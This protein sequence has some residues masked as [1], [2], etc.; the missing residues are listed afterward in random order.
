[1]RIFLGIYVL[2]IS[3]LSSINVFADALNLATNA[4]LDTGAL[5]VLYTCDGKDVS[6]ELSWTNTPPKTKSYA[7]IVSD[8]DAPSGTFYHW[9]VFNIPSTTT[10]LTEGTTALPKNA[11]VGKNSEGEKKYSGP[12]PPKGSAHTYHFTLYALDSTLA[13]PEGSDG[14]EMM[15]NMKNHIISKSDLTAVYSRWLK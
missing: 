11:L 13:L 10:E 7:L 3:L 4:F 14:K 5:P 9:V 15:D 2:M 8:P 6:P 12:C 1:M